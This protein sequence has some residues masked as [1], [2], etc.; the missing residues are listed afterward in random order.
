MGMNGRAN[1]LAKSRKVES[2]LGCKSGLQKQEK[3]DKG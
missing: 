3:G 2:C 1:R